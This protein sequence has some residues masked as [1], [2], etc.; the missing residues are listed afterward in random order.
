MTLPHKNKFNSC[1]R[2]SPSTLILSRSRDICRKI[3]NCPQPVQKELRP[4]IRRQLSTVPAVLGV[5]QNSVLYKTSPTPAGPVLPYLS[6]AWLQACLPQSR[7]MSTPFVAGSNQTCSAN[8]TQRQPLDHSRKH[9]H[10]CRV[11]VGRQI[12]SPSPHGLQVYSFDLSLGMNK[13]FLIFPAGIASLSH[14]LQPP[15]STPRPAS[16]MLHPL[17]SI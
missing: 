2:I 9:P 3:N 10:L 1:M 6:D 8:R 17:L 7:F 5:Y 4:Q 15:S 11:P 12:Y 13:S 14:P 16:L